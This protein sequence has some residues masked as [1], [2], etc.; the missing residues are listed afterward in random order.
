M[1]PID[2]ENCRDIFTS[3]RF[4][5]L[6]PIDVESGVAIHADESVDPSVVRFPRLEVVLRAQQFSEFRDPSRIRLDPELDE[7]RVLWALGRRA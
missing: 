7:R 3:P 4:L 6:L 5:E 1:N 2:I